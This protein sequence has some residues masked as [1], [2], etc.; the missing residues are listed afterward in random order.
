VRQLLAAVLVAFS[1]T[2]SFAAAVPGQP[3]PAFTLPDTN[4]KQVSLAEFRGKTVVLEWSNPGCP[5]VMKHY[6]SGNMPALQK[7]YAKDVVWLTVNSTTNGHSDYM[8]GAQLN[9]FSK[10]HSAVPARYLLDVD[11]HVGKAYGARTT[12]HMYIVDASGKLVYVGA[13]DDIPSASESDV[14]TAKN[15]VAAA[16]EEI[17]AG[18]PVGN[19]STNPYGCSVKYKH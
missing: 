4:G 7:K 10:Q 5:F 16:I 12:P 3:A 13:I 15:F 17:K 18:K 1:A 8:T 9:E 2:A 11:G 19:A 14:K 6:R